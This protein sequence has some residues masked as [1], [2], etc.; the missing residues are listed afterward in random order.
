[1]SMIPKWMLSSSWWNLSFLIWWRQ[2][3]W[4]SSQKSL[5]TR[6]INV[7][8]LWLDV[9]IFI[10]ASILYCVTIAK[11]TMLIFCFIWTLTCYRI[12]SSARPHID[13]FLIQRLSNESILHSLTYQTVVMEYELRSCLCCQSPAS[14]NPLP[15]SCYTSHCS[16]RDSS[17]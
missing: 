5:I 2:Q 3:S 13:S 17:L 11:W 7:C 8:S 16:L 4:W 1:M 15:S 9:H 12:A 6:G 10:I 14:V